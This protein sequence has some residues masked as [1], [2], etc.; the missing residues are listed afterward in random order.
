MRGCR[1]PLF[2]HKI[3]K[4]KK[5]LK[6]DSQNS[7]PKVKQ[8]SKMASPKDMLN[9]WMHTPLGA[10][11]SYHAWWSFVAIVKLPVSLIYL[12]ISFFFG[13]IN[14]L[15]GNTKIPS[16][17]RSTKLVVISGC[18]TGFGRELSILL[19]K[20]CGYVVL[21]GCLKTESE[22]S[23]KKICGDNLYTAPLDVAKDDSVKTFIEKMEKILS[24]KDGSSKISLHAVVNNAGIGNFGAAD[25]MQMEQFRFDMEV[26]YFGVIRLTKACLPFL[27]DV[28][29]ANRGSSQPAPRIVNVTSIAGLVPSPFMSSYCATKHAA[30]AFTSSLRMEMK[31]WGIHVVT[32]N[33]TVH[34]T[35]IASG[36]AATI[37][38]CWH[39][40]DEATRVQ[41]G[42]QYVHQVASSSLALIDQ[43]TWNPMN[44]VNRMEDAVSLYRPRSQYLVGMDALCIM[45]LTR[46]FPTWLSEFFIELSMTIFLPKP[47]AMK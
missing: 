4:E 3:L 28:A 8:T 17:V 24:S 29:I 11:L 13:A 14:V 36:A 25:W 1:L 9:D 7:K 12:G 19:S 22:D 35:P 44:V 38:R 23:L 42:D 30:E 6:N 47:A 39:K 31:S 20:K 10:F 34:R 21:A 26:N 41:Y 18:D 37:Q 5:I 32:L 27:K 43:A 45:S 15:F 33:P 40:A 2:A 16:N 46:Q